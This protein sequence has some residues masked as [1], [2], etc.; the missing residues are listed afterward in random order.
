MNTQNFQARGLALLVIPTSATLGTFQLDGTIFSGTTALGDAVIPAATLTFDPNKSTNCIVS[1]INSTTQPLVGTT[2]PSLVYYADVCAEPAPGQPGF[3]QVFID[4]Q[5]SL[6]GP[7]K[8]TA[9]PVMFNPSAKLQAV[10]K[11]TLDGSTVQNQVSATV[12]FPVDKLSGGCT[13]NG[14][15]GVDQHGNVI[16]GTMTCSTKWLPYTATSP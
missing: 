1:A 9:N 6:S 7:V 13:D 15:G 8:T 16:P 10:L 11:F 2:Q 5:E 12:T 14:D 3:V 4:V